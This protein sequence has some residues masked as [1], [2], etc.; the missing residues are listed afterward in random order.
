M[1][2]SSMFLKK[3]ILS[4]LFTKRL[5][6]Y[7]AAKWLNHKCYEEKTCIACFDDFAHLNYSYRISETKRDL[8]KLIPDKANCVLY[9]TINKIENGLS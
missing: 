8:F 7:S 4:K 6:I 2:C 5:T 1:E 9:L 3:F